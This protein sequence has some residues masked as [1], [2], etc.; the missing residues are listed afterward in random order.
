LAL[1]VAV[2]A[3]GV[4]ADVRLL[5]ALGQGSQDGL[6]DRGGELEA[7]VL[8]GA[9]QGLPEG[10]AVLPEGVRVQAGEGG[11]DGLL[12]GLAGLHLLGTGGALLPA[13]G[14]VVEGAFLGQ[15][16]DALGGGLE[17]EAQGA[18]HGDLAEAEVLVVEDLR[19]LA[20]LEGAVE[21]HDGRAVRIAD[22][23]ALVAQGLAHLLVEVHG[24]D[25][26]DLALALR[27]LAVGDDP[28][29]GEDAGVE[30]ELVGQGDD[31]LQPVVLQD[32]A[33]DLALPGAGVAGEQGRAVEDDGDAAAPRADRLHLADHVLQEQEGA[34]VDARQ[35][36]AEAAGEAFV[37]VLVLYGLLDLLPLHAEGRVGEHV[38]E[39]LAGVAVVGEAVAAGDV[40]RVLGLEQHVRL[41]DG[42]GLVE[43]LAEQLQ[44]GLRVAL[45]QVVLGHRE[46]AAGPA[47]RVVQGLDDARGGQGV[48]VLP[49]Q[50]L[51][52]ELDDLA[53]G[54][55]L[56]G[57]LVGLLGEAPDQVLEDPAH[58]V[59]GHHAGVQ[60]HLGEALHHQVEDVGLVQARHLLGEL[61]AL[62]E[63]LPHVVAEGAQV[64]VEV[65][66]D[67]V[68]VVQQAAEVEA[69][70]VVEVGPADA[71][72]DGGGL[73][74]AAAREPIV[75]LHDRVPGVLQHAVQA[76]QHGE[77]QDDLA[78]VVL[79][80]VAAQQVGDGPQEAG[81][82]G[83]A[84]ELAALA[85][86]AGGLRRGLIG[87]R[88]VARGGDGVAGR[89][90]GYGEWGRPVVG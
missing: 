42:E 8:Q 40:A 58:L 7:G 17:V 76:P 88:G 90:L 81:R 36:G 50:Q 75:L 5:V 89:R 83:E 37:A 70:G 20:F 52:H 41:A 35:A 12:H 14:Q 64:G 18:L 69:G 13:L 86:L 33:A 43:L 77:G 73:L 54:E 84:G 27:R 9:V 60:V 47:G 57:G 25:E 85:R 55:V 61:E 23:V 19:A 67:V 68:R 65:L 44:V 72:Q 39:A 59:V 49:E 45:G 63:D 46:H 48:A 24:V 30:E 26:L 62:D 31:G 53:G 78:V 16:C 10:V 29:V 66:G 21:V 11:E 32:P 38:V 28:H 80:E 34:V 87:E 82:L 6:A 3:L 1:G 56:A 74:D 2:K 51:D 22:L 15:A 79:L 4:G 71:A